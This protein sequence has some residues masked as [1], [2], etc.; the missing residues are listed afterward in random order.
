M[1][2]YVHTYNHMSKILIAVEI[3]SISKVEKSSK[4]DN[5][6]VCTLN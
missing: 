4:E 5:Y 1:Y 2:V 6:Q 3:N